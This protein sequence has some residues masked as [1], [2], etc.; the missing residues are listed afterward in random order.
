[1]CTG[2]E[3]VA[4]YLLR[5]KCGGICLAHTQ[6]SIQVS[7]LITG[8]INM[9]L[10]TYPQPNNVHDVG[11]GKN[12][13]CSPAGPAFGLGVG[14]SNIDMWSIDYLHVIALYSIFN[15]PENVMSYCYIHF[16]NDSM[17]AASYAVL[18]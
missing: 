14:V 18:R 2:N 1:M 17:P 3:P 8:M 7:F 13:T 10:F 4:K 15:A 6:I 16:M 5:N 9:Y 11:T 12:Y